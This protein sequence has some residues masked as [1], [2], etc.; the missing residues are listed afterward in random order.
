MLNPEIMYIQ[1]NI[2]ALRA[3]GLHIMEL[4]TRA[5]FALVIRGELGRA[6]KLWVCK[7]ET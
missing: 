2:P 7:E 3:K 1:K 5:R 4:D 6:S